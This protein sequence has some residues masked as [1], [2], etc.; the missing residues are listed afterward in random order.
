MI[1]KTRMLIRANPIEAPIPTPTFAPMLKKDAGGVGESGFEAVDAGAV[2]GW[3]VIVDIKL[4]VDGETP[5]VDIM[6]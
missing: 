6:V 3:D 2:E 4:M 5:I 1:M